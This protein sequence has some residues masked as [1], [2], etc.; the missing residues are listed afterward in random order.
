MRTAQTESLPGMRILHVTDFHF[1]KRW[2]AWLSEAALGYDREAPVPNYIEID[3]V[4]RTA[5]FQSHG[6]MLERISLE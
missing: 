6:Y 2:Y 4:A 5:V 1:R 3:T